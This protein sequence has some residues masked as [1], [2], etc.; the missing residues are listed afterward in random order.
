MQRHNPPRNGPRDLPRDIWALGLVSLFMDV[1][2]ESIH[3]LLPV[4]LVTVLGAG[5]LTVGAIEGVGEATAAFAKLGSGWLSD[6]L[7]RRKV[8]AVAGY[9]LGAL[10]KP[11]FALAPTPGWV[12]L[13]RFSDRLGKGIRGAPRDA[14]VG[15][16]TPADRKGAAYGLRQ[17]LDTVGAFLGPLLAMGLMAA[18]DNDF[19][20]VFWIALIPGLVAVGILAVAVHEPRARRGSPG[21]PPVRWGQLARLGKP[22]WGVVGVA[23]VL[24]LAR[25][26]EAFL[27]L[28][29]RDQGLPLAL[30]PLVLIV[31][32][33]VYAL[34][35]YPAGARSDRTGKR[36][37]L[38]AGF[39]AL[40]AAD[41]ALAFAPGLALT[42]TG[43]ALWGLHM[44]LTQ[45]LL[46]ALV[47]ATA[48]E[49]LRGTGF[50]IFHLVTGMAVL[51]ASL[52]AG[53]LWEVAG[54]AATFLAG[55]GLTALGM[56][57]LAVLP[58]RG[59]DA[60]P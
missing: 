18:L 46:A 25:F 59:E 54:P 56:A 57:G 40:L 32:N 19:R 12:F 35:A 3:A 50:G 11:I 53:G 14:L 42:M 43:I 47:A 30:V 28:R 9:G 49:G 2:S 60:G 38:A 13:A 37:L 39:A 22:F 24:T 20:A 6:R 31:M 27:V 26:S 52:I 29:A 33:V 23:T 4:F 8:L 51:G 34:T 5:T 45:G 41:L 10:S 36:G 1:S 55:A 44:G 17:S 48:P 7:G 16:L 15:D 58:G 21:P